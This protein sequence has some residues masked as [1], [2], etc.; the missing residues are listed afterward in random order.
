[1][2][3]KKLQSVWFPTP[4]RYLYHG[5]R[6][7]NATHGKGTLRLA[8]SP[9]SSHP[10]FQLQ[11]QHQHQHTMPLDLDLGYSEIECIA[12]LVSPMPNKQVLTYPVLCMGQKNNARCGNDRR[13]LLVR[14]TAG[15]RIARPYPASR[16][17]GTG[18]SKKNSLHAWANFATQ[19]RRRKPLEGRDADPCRGGLAQ[20][21]LATGTGAQPQLTEGREVGGNKNKLFEQQTSRHNK[22]SKKNSG[23]ELCRAVVPETAVRAG[24]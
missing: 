17:R 5:N 22:T 11:L 24:A 14:V 19:H 12:L 23:V 3:D 15:F 2:K 6:T 4:G 18:Y 8:S 9:P 7:H 13:T 21:K 20:Q 16:V 10:Q 1:M